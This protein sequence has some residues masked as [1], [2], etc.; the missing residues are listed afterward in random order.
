MRSRAPTCGNDM[1]IIWSRCEN[2]VILHFGLIFTYISYYFIIVS[3]VGAQVPDIGRKNHI[4]SYH[5]LIFRYH[6]HN[7]VYS[8]AGGSADTV[9]FEKHSEGT[10][11]RCISKAAEHTVCEC[12][13]QAYRPWGRRQFVSCR[14]YCSYG[15]LHDLH[16]MGC[17]VKG[18][19][20]QLQLNRFP[21]KLLSMLPAWIPQICQ[22]AVAHCA[23]PEYDINAQNVFGATDHGP[24]AWIYCW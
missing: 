14:L 24:S 10:R 12:Y 23:A 3:Y 19:A 15:T 13:R 6:L 5:L 4:C 22:W 20:F 18:V 8:W 21:V 11:L 7:F 1:G 17:W 2:N 16:I 9:I